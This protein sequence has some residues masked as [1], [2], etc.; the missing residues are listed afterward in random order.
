MEV[1]GETSELMRFCSECLVW[2]KI[3]VVNSKLKAQ[4]INE[5]ICDAE[6]KRSCLSEYGDCLESVMPTKVNLH[7][8]EKGGWKNVTCPQR[9][10]CRCRAQF[11]RAIQ[12]LVKG[13]ANIPTK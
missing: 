11:G 9:V 3:K 12:K 5:A 2:T 10:G 4:Y 13:R 8:G 1:N 6:K 7:F